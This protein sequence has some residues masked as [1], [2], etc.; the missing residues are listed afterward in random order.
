MKSNPSSHFELLLE[1]SRACD[2]SALVA[3]AFA[4]IDV[5]SARE[6]GLHTLDYDKG[7]ECFEK[8]AELGDTNAMLNLADLYC[9]GDIAEQDFAKA[10]IYFEQLAAI[11]SD[12]YSGYAQYHLAQMYRHGIGVQRDS[13]QAA[14][15]SEMAAAQGYEHSVEGS[16]E[17]TEHSTVEMHVDTML[18]FDETLA[19]AEAGDV[20]AQ[21]ALAEIYE[22][23]VLI[24]Q[25]LKLSKSWYKK[26]AKKGDA[27][28]Q[29]RLS[30]YYCSDEDGLPPDAKK[31]LKWMNRSASQG[32]LKAI[33]GLGLMYYNGVF[34][35]QCLIKAKDFY[36]KAAM[37]GYA[38]A[39]SGLAAM[40]VNGDGVEQNF[41]EAVRLYELGCR[42]NDVK[43]LQGL[44]HLYYT[45]QGCTQNFEKSR[46]LLALA[47]G[48]GSVMAQ[49]RLGLMCFYGL[50]GSVDF[51]HAKYWLENSPDY[52]NAFTV[53]HLGRIYH[54][55]LSAEKDTAIAEHYYL[56][57]ANAG[58]STA[59]TFLGLFYAE[60]EDHQNYDE[61]VQWLQQ[62]LEPREIDFPVPFQHF[63]RSY[64]DRAQS[65]LS[66]LVS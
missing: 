42:G 44:S 40:H 20:R 31:A 46:E 24:A 63:L 17:L 50:G 37:Q 33:F 51:E 55:G 65:T 43:S 1:Q 28:A 39:Y 64:Q 15:W 21:V 60:K 14:I 36:E 45:G 10:K 18:G 47:A 26:A 13:E 25:D 11:E 57:A 38:P 30:I 56:E 16:Y 5:D 59:Q 41:S 53:A 32:H 3:L 52:H 9:I 7:V 8:A 61:A 66:S 62:A 19:L 48:Q 23:G 4:Y 34:V 29:L 35:R 27:H 6:L 12:F 2:P 58:C 49:K 22:N 54:M